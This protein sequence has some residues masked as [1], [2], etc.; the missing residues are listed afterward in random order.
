MTAYG[1]LVSLTNTINYIFDSSHFRVV[2]PSLDVIKPAINELRSLKPILQKLDNT[3]PSRCRKKV[4]A[5][6]GRIKD[7]IWEF[8][9]KLESLF[10]DQILSQ[11]PADHVYEE[12]KERVWDFK[13][14]KESLFSLQFP[15][16]F[17]F[18]SPPPDQLEMTSNIQRR[19]RRR[20]RDKHKVG[21]SK[22][23]RKFRS[24]RD[25]LV[26]SIDLRCLQDD[27]GFFVRALEDMKR[28]YIYELCNMGEDEAAMSSTIGFRGIN[29]EMIGLSD[30]FQQ[31]KRDLLEDSWSHVEMLV[32][33]AGVGKTTLAAKI[34][35]D[36]EILS[37]FE[38]R[39]WV[40][41]GRKPE[42]SRVSR[43]ILAQLCRGRLGFANADD[44]LKQ[45][46]EGKKCLIVLDDVWEA[47]VMRSLMSFL[48]HPEKATIVILLTA[49]EKSVLENC[50]LGMVSESTLVRFLNLE[51]SKKLLCEKVFGEEI[52]P[53]Q[54]DNAA[55][56]IAKNCEGLPLMILT[57]ADIISKSEQNRDPDYWRDIAEER[58]LV[59]TYAYN[60][61]SEVLFPSYDYL[62]QDLKMP[63]LFMGVFPREYNTPP[64]KIINMLT[65]EGWFLDTNIKESFEDSVWRCLDKLCLDKNLVLFSETSIYEY[66]M[67][68]GHR[69]YKTCRLHS[70]WRHVCRGE[71]RKNKFYQVLKRLVDGTEEGI[72][73][74]RCLCLENNMLFG[75]KEFCNSVR[76]KCAFLTRSIFFYGPYHQYPISIDVGFRFLRELDALSLRFYTFP[77]EILRLVQLKYLSLTCNGELPATISKLFNLQFLIIHPHMNIRCYR[78][79]SYVPIQIWD[80][81]ELEHIEILGKILIVPS[82]VTSL[83]KL[84][85][86]VGVNATIATISELSKRIPNIS[87]LVVQVELTPYDDHN[88]VLSCFGCISTLESL[89]TL[90][91][92]IINPV[93]KCGYV[94]L[95]NPSSLTFPRGLKKLHLSGMGFPW[96]YMDVIGSLP[97]LEVLKL[98]SYAFR[99]PTWEARKESFSM[100]EFLLIEDTDLVYLNLRFGELCLLSYVSVKHCYKLE[101]IH[102]P[103]HK[104]RKIELVDCNPLALT[105]AKK[106][107]MTPLSRLDV[108]ASSS[109]YEKPI[110]VNFQRSYSDDDDTDKDDGKD[111]DD[112]EE[113]SSSSVRIYAKAS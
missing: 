3:S 93:A 101:R 21:H 109:I 72:K 73:G 83:E 57:V 32:G 81:K 42:L 70:S 9:D 41:V 76:L 26:F 110:T 62:P 13:D 40:T 34:Y 105:C 52:C 90:K 63:F 53:P 96:E 54:L 35:Q 74:Q 100:L 65:A 94:V 84:L 59:F 31:L 24:R 45:R 28:K 33:M 29:S 17:Q 79:P 16:Q 14:L 36:P 50:T 99:G 104:D 97:N 8:E 106:L 49:R 25:A 80:M 92:S 43:S 61:I 7:F 4:N 112:V 103:G 69:K 91:C 78:A 108:T 20:R 113:E 67:P 85:T 89:K 95:E 37:N 11:I 87:K 12:T 111:S 19:R 46:A 10:T 56:K 5:W 66:G 22:S 55:T 102:W 2:E 64:S 44:Y 98:R 71:A 48:P 15:L 58:N 6:D 82:H 107:H 47:Q 86:L 23:S 77:I 88:L 38:C 68:I 30:E 51:E 60:Q 75:I 18:G 39:A 1:A 27:V